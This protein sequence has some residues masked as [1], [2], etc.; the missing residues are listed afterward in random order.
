M[1]DFIDGQ[2]GVH[3]VEPICATLPI[4]PSTYYQH[5]LRESDPE[6]APQRVRR[7]AQLRG[8]IQ[9]VWQQN[10]SVYGA[11]KVWRELKRL[12]VR[13][14]RCTVERLMSAMGLRLSLIHI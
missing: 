9:Q 5:K 3:G 2:R 14:A 8:E 13:V 4:A 11:R 12:G 7:D 1:V 10:M 6:R